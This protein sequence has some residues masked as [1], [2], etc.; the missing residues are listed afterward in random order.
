MSLAACATLRMS[1]VRIR[2]KEPPHSRLQI[3]NI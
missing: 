2:E 3:K 1:D